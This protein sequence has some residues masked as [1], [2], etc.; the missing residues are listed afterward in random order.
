MPTLYFIA[1][2]IGNLEDITIRAKRILAEVDAVLAEDKR[3]SRKLLDHLEIKT[4]LAVWHQHSKGTDWNKIK[5]LLS[6]DKDLALITDAGTPGLSDPGGQLI[7]K[8]LEE[9]PETEIV[10]IPGPSSLAAIISV[11]G[12]ALDKFLFLGF[13]PH[14]KG[15]QTLVA[16]I[17][18]SKI[19]VIFLE[20]VHRIE[21]ALDQ[22]GDCPKQL[23]V[24]RELT[25]QF[26][27]IYRGTAQEILA[28]LNSDKTKVKGEFIVIVN[29]KK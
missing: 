3:V 5:K 27:T 15:R 23:I 25:K 7:A 26:E 16:E 28:I 20:S 21:K 22:L 4:P 12:I 24:G 11:A 18:D 10:P 17:K 1:T 2:P 13:L 19:P 6:E 29:K 14:K 9:F 8:V